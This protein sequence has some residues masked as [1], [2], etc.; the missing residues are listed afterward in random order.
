MFISVLVI[1]PRSWKQTECP[2]KNE[3]IKKEVVNYSAI[4]GNGGLIH[5]TSQMNLANL[6]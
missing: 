4:K 5:A 2:S 1:I 3:W 6:C